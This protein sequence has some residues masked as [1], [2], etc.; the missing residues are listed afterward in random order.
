M[1]ILTAM[2]A[3]VAFVCN[4]PS[5][6]AIQSFSTFH[7]GVMRAI[8]KFYSFPKL[9]LLQPQQLQQS[10]HLRKRS[11]AED[12]ITRSPSHCLRGDDAAGRNSTAL[13]QILTSC[14]FCSD[15]TLQPFAIVHTP[16][17]IS[18]PSVRTVALP[19]FRTFRTQSASFANNT[20][21]RVLLNSHWA[22]ARTSARGASG[23]CRTLEAA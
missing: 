13:L 23:P 21:A 6:S 8:R 14:P 16:N 4:V 17:A 20:H 5:F 10:R 2:T 1:L 7:H 11:I 9:F 3:A 18:T 15:L 19:F 12:D 22:R